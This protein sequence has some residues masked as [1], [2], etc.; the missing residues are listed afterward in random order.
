ML[1]PIYIGIDAGGSA[2]EL[3]AEAGGQALRRTGDGVN[4]QRDGAAR[5]TDVLSRLIAEAL[6]L[7]DH[8]GTGS[9]CLGVA[10]AGRSDDRR[11]LAEHVRR[12]FGAPLDGYLLAV[13]HDARVALEA[14]FE[15]ESGVLVI[16]GTGSVVLARTT[17]GTLER[18]GGWG[19]RIGD[20][21]S[22]TAIGTAGLSV[23]AASFDGG[24]PTALCDPLGARFGIASPE[25]LIRA[26]YADG[27]AVQAL[28]PLVVAAAESGDEVSA[29]ILKAQ[30]SA[31]AQRA[32]WLVERAGEIAPRIALM[33]GLASEA[34]YRTCLAD[35][36]HRRLPGWEAALPSRRPMD[37][38]LALARKIAA[39]RRDQEIDSGG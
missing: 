20:D 12:R 34:H 28:A 10:G 16:A 22:G 11:R 21:G 27:W 29:R 9:I 17:A 35:A 4:F 39:E 23:V 19:P 24:P 30:A 31:L 13:E 37:G 3:R 18:A 25:D 7:L 8:D 36:L 2:T 26:V 14:A 15:G 1:P 32:G 6:A 33:G 38:A 5:S